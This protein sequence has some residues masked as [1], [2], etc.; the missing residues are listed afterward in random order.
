MAR[1][2]H[3]AE[4][5]AIEAGENGGCGCG[6]GCGGGGG[7]GINIVVNITV[8][9]EAMTLRA[10]PTDATGP[11]VNPPDQGPA[12]PP[13]PDI[14]T[15]P[16]GDDL[17]HQHGYRLEMQ[18]NR[19]EM[20]QYLVESDFKAKNSSASWQ[21]MYY[22][23]TA[24]LN[25]TTYDYAGFG[26]SDLYGLSTLTVRTKTDY[27]YYDSASVSELS[28][29]VSFTLTALSTTEIKVSSDDTG[30][31]YRVIIMPRYVDTKHNTS[32]YWDNYL[33]QG[34]DAEWNPSGGA[35]TFEI[36]NLPEPGE[37][38]T[39]FVFFV[40]HTSAVFNNTSATPVV[41]SATKTITLPA[42]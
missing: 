5:E 3:C 32:P 10:T 39:F 21:P 36:D 37:T 7:G 11:I 40:Q 9:G 14:P 38:N 12:D 19:L 30:S 26:V 20:Y 28:Q 35:Q 1:E 17:S 18:G 31:D 22:F 23:A 33:A 42:T 27:A 13:S 2:G 29:G 41:I 6:C 4:T 34:V 25:S 16:Y 24:I 15:A 8:N